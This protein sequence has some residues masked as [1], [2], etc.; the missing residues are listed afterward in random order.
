MKKSNGP[1]L[2]TAEAMER[3]KAKLQSQ[4]STTEE[5]QKKPAKKR[6]KE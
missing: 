1:P 3:Y 5:V 4:S 6:K 2:L